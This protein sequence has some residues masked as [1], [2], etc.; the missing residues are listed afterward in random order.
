LATAFPRS[1]GKQALTWINLFK[2]HEVKVNAMS[3]SACPRP[4]STGSA[5][6]ICSRTAAGIPLVHVS[7]RRAIL[8]MEKGVAGSRVFDDAFRARGR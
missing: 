7:G 8:A 1:S 5:I 3:P 4:A 6:S 2:F